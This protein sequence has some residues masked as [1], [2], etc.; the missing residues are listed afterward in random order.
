[1]KNK[2]VLCT[3]FI[4]ALFSACAFAVFAKTPTTPKIVLAATPKGNWDI[5]LMNPDGTEQ[6]NLTHH[7]AN[8]HSPAW[9]PTGEHIL[10]CSDRDLSPGSVDLY[11]MDP[12]GSNVRPVFEKSATRASP[13]WSPDGK[14]IAY[15]RWRHGELI[16]YTATIDGKSE[17][18]LASGGGPTWSPDGTEIAV[19]TG[20]ANLHHQIRFINFRTRREKIFFPRKAKPSSMGSIKWSPMADKLAF[21][22]NHQVPLKDFLETETIYTLNRDG[23]GLNQIVPEVGLRA[24]APVWSPDGRTLLYQQLIVDKAL[25]KKQWQIFKVAAIGGQPVEVGPPGWYGLG[26]WFDPAYALPVSPQPHLLTTT[27]GDVKK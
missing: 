9:A 24:K 21:S 23:G 19:V 8:D 18:R 22:W 5:L 13:A 4:F 10:F 16:T 7:P 27:W 3:T 2:N 20:V 12:D 26:D 17:E 11:L 15:Q 14:H 6:V 1:M 25:A